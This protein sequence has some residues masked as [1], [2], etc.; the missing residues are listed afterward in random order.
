MRKRAGI[1]KIM[2][3]CKKEQAWEKEQVHVRENEKEIEGERERVDV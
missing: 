3:V 2:T 1:R